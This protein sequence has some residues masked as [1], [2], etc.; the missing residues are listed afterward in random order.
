M[1]VRNHDIRPFVLVSEY[2]E[3]TEYAIF[4]DARE[5]WCRIGDR[6]KFLVVHVI[7]ARSKLMSLLDLVQPRELLTP[8][9]HRSPTVGICLAFWEKRSR[10]TQIVWLT[11]M[12][13]VL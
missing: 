10:G 11:V 5:D 7:E 3:C 2:G 8:V 9:L 4:V 13:L 6:L 1:G 12:L